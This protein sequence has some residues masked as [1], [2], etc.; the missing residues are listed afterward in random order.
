[1]LLEA[2]TP[3]ARLAGLARIAE[4]PE[5]WALWLPRCRS[6][7]TF[8]MRFALDLVWLGGEG[9]VLRVD[10]AVGA[11]RMRSCLRA[12]SV[13]EARSGEGGRLASVL[14]AQRATSSVAGAPVAGVPPAD[15]PLSG[16]S[17]AGGCPS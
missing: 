8:G 2:S 14:L 6:V 16:V 11:L 5:G 1:M 15:C 3:H 4:I 13:V 7:H 9:E 10:A 17:S 12:R